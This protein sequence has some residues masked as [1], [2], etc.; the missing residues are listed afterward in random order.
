MRKE[1]KVCERENEIQGER[2]I[3]LGREGERERDTGRERQREGETL[4]LCMCIMGRWGNEPERYNGSLHRPQGRTLHN[5]AQSMKNATDEEVRFHDS[6]MD[7]ED[8]FFC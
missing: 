7:I 2:Y 4:H 6:F 5:A 3:N 8:L 1:E